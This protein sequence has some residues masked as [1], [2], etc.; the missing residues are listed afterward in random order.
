MVL[1]R[2]AGARSADRTAAPA[3]MTPRLAAIKRRGVDRFGPKRMTVD[4]RD[5]IEIRAPADSNRARNTY[6]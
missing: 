3:A 5:R 6:E 4:G 1:E 2:A